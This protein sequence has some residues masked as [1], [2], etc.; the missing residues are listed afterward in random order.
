[1]RDTKLLSNLA[2]VAWDSALVLHDTRTADYFQVRNLCQ[3]SQNL[4]LDAICEKGVLLF[5]AEIIKGQDGD[6]FLRRRCCSCVCRESRIAF[7]FF[8][9]PQDWWRKDQR[10]DGEG[11]QQKN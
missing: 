1:M 8:T 10:H 7:R 11:D 3:V 4:I 9:R 2:Q 5:V 6:T